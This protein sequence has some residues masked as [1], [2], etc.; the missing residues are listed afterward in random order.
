MDDVSSCQCNANSTY[1]ET[2]FFLVYYSNQQRL[3][4]KVFLSEMRHLL[5]DLCNLMTVNSI[6]YPHK[7]LLSRHELFT[8]INSNNKY[9]L[10]KHNVFTKVSYYLCFEILRIK[11]YH[12][13]KQKLIKPLEMRWAHKKQLFSVSVSPFLIWLGGNPVCDISIRAF[14]HN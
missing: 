9:T 8:A 12:E 11:K 14:L 7:H 2:Y 13:Q 5:N 4:Q 3:C 1:E 10:K 6:G